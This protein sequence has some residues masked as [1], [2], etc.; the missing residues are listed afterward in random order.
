MLCI[1]HSNKDIYF[2]LATE[3]YLLK[4]FQEDIFMLWQSEF[5]AIVGKY[6]HVPNEIDLDFAQEHRIPVA[7]RLTGG[8]AV[9]H[10]SGNFNLTYIRRT[11][12]GSFSEF[13]GRLAGFLTSLASGI[14]TD[15]RNNLFIN[16]LKISGSAQCVYKNRSLHHCTLLFS[17]DLDTLKTILTPQ[18][19]DAQKILKIKPVESVRSNTT[20]IR[21]HLFNKNLNPESFKHELWNYF[22]KSNPEN[23]LYSLTNQDLMQINRIKEKYISNLWI[24]KY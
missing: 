21:E 13:T 16:G 19:P 5:A 12:A 4:N 17:S 11:E 15:K 20:N 6:Q 8:G 3:E 9:F 18:N 24:Y 10:D 22:L 14:E 2:N 23:I 7:R 1:N